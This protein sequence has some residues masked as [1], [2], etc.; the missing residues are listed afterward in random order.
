[1]RRTGALALLSALAHGTLAAADSLPRGVGPECKS[2][3]SSS[4]PPFPSHYC[5]D[6][7][8]LWAAEYIYLSSITY[9]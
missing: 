8:A 7:K 1:M 2:S 4:L 6:S 5:I 9:L 3:S